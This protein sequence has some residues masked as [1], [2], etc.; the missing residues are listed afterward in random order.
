VSVHKKNLKARKRDLLFRE[1]STSHSPFY[2]FLLPSF[3][4]P[5]RAQ[6]YAH[7]TK[8][9]MHTLLKHAVSLPTAVRQAVRFQSVNVSHSLSLSLSLTLYCFY[10]L[11]H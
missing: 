9:T 8:E 10:F 4:P 6:V 11:W 5:C 2:L 1:V 7:A 3:L